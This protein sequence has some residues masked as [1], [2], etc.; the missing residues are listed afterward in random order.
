MTTRLARHYDVLTPWERLPLLVAA[1]ARGDTVEIGRLSRSAPSDVFWAPD[2]HAL[3][4]GLSQLAHHY[5]LQQL[6]RAAL[7]WKTISF[8][9]QKPPEAR[10][11]GDGRVE[12]GLA[13]RARVLAYWFVVL[14]DGWQLF[15]Q[16]LGIDP[17][18]PLRGLP[19]CEAVRQMDELARVTSCTTDEVSAWLG[20][21]LRRDERSAGGAT[22]FTETPESVEMVARRMLAFLEGE[23]AIWS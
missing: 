8:M 4:Q 1:T 20:E 15:C 17:D 5:L 7:F 18:V 19:G 22:E 21:A 12:D 3:V 16:R 9:D 23:L 11:R 10:K 14:A 13:R 6:D 2:Y